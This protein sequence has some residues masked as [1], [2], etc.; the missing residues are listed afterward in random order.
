MQS[1]SHS[2]QTDTPP[3]TL[4]QST[5]I[6]RYEDSRATYV[7]CN[8]RD[9]FVMPDEEVRHENVHYSD[10][11]VEK[12]KKI[13]DESTQ[14]ALADQAQ[15]S[16]KS[17]KLSAKEVN[18]TLNLNL[19]LSVDPENPTLR[20]IFNFISKLLELVEQY[21]IML[22]IAIPLRFRHHL[23]MVA[24]KCYFRVHRRLLGNS[25]GIHVNASDEYHA[26]TSIMWWGNLFPVTLNRIRFALN[27]LQ[28][29]H[30]PSW[31][32]KSRSRILSSPLPTESKIEET[33]TQEPR[34]HMKK[35]FRQDEKLGDVLVGYYIQICEK[36]VSEK[37]IFWIYGG[38][39]LGG[40]CEGN[41]GIGEFLCLII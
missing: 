17:R 14:E 20:K 36:K 21:G 23:A 13:E 31:A 8:S 24:W 34:S 6:I 16:T 9:S 18:E 39:Y 32:L 25:T 22:W 33:R 30:I 27:Q 15:N 7:K 38:A 37:A 26:L 1:Q 4:R 35:V 40:D 28:V 41:V 12:E 2:L 5:Q 10:A 11:E 3:G 29:V 19:G